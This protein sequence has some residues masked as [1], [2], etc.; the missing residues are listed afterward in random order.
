MPKI[1]LL[2]QHSI[3]CDYPVWR[4]HLKRNRDVFNKVILYPSDHY[5]K[6]SFKDFVQKVIPETW[7]TPVEI[8]WSKADWRQ[9]ETIPMLNQS[10]AEWVYFNEPDWFVKDYQKFYEKVIE[11]MEK[12]AEAIGWMNMTNFPYLHPSS[13]FV[14]RSVLEKTQ[15]DFS[16]HSEINGCDHFAMI[17]HDLKKLGAKIVTFEELGFKDFEDCFHLG[18]LT[19]NF[20]EIAENNP[21]TSWHRAEIFFV[22]NYWS[23]KAD[24]EQSPLYLN[25]SLQMEQ[26]MK[27]GV[28]ECKNL[29]P[30]TSEWS[31]FFK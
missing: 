26:L 24:V 7:V 23:R 8:D 1:D 6:V 13:L 10:N 30:E 31:K 12:G 29:D 5:R 4:L 22:Q 21:Y 16:A 2:M 3:Y 19:Q 27:E 25:I 11:T 17:T 20:I 18:G 15:K 9:V 14:K 28:P